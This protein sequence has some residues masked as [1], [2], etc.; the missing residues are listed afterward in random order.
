MKTYQLLFIFFIFIVFL[1]NF[2]KEN[3]ENI[4]EKNEVLSDEPDDKQFYACDHEKFNNDP[5]FPFERYPNIPPLVI[6]TRV[7][8]PTII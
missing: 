1:C 5:D 6:H 7:S 3:Y 8:T 4:H 2:N